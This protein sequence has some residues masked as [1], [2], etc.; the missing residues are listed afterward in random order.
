MSGFDLGGSINSAAEWACSAP[1]IRT[2]V[3][4]AVF[5]AILITAIV[6]VI[7]L[8]TYYDRA[9]YGGSK[10]A[11]RSTLYVGL[12]VMMVM[13]VHHYAVQQAA[14][15]AA[16][17]KGVR[18]VFSGIQASREYGAGVGTPVVPRGYA[19]DEGAEVAT[20]GASEARPAN[21]APYGEA[22]GDG[23]GGLEIEDIPYPPPRSS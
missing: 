11:V 8:G 10:Q 16:A 1:I 12:L 14:R 7:M 22:P 15:D 2:I 17:H 3:N 4:N 13:F 19:A 5:T 20:G 23:D 21:V 9:K 6:A 18:D